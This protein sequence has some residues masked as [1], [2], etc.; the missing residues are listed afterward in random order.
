MISYSLVLQ[1]SILLYIFIIKL[2]HIYVHVVLLQ[3]Y[4]HQNVL[5]IIDPMYLINVSHVC[6]IIHVLASYLYVSFIYECTC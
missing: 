2:V 6:I 1:Q 4:L 3:I 5:L